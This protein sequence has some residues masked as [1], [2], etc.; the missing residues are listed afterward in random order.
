MPD[1][2][3]TRVA[4]RMLEISERKLKEWMRSGRVETS[5][6]DGCVW[7]DVDSARALIDS[8]RRASAVDV[9]SVRRPSRQEAYERALAFFASPSVTVSPHKRKRRA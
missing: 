9:T 4:A 1:Y 3:R 2:H 6:V 5:K 8:G 7:V